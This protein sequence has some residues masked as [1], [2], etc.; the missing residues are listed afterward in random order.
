MINASPQEAA[1]Q[2]SASFDR[3][4]LDRTGVKGDYDFALEIEWPPDAGRGVP[5]RFPSASALYSAL[6]AMGLQ[7]ESTQ[8]AF[9][10]L[11]IDQ[12]E[13]PSEN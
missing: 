13:K 6:Q 9:E 4:V 11:V 3:S 12:V 10:V 1:D 2:F 5:G 8:T 7:L